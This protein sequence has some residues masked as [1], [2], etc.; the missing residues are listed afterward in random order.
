MGGGPPAI[1]GG[2]AIII[3][4][5]IGGITGPIPGGKGP[6]IS[7]KEGP[8]DLASVH[9]KEEEEDLPA[10]STN[11][12]VRSPMDVLSTWLASTSGPK[13]GGGPI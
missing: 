12:D 3:G 7:L 1:I 2:P 6:R 10:F 9:T 8:A 13:A 5:G 11:L 4:G